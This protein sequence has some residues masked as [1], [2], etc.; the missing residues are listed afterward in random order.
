VASSLADTHYFDGNPDQHL[1]NSFYFEADPIP[2]FHY[3]A[4]PDPA[5][6]QTDANL[7]VITGVQTLH[8]SIV[9]VNVPP[10]LHF[11]PS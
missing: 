3:Y 2:S 9:S 5:H 6:H 4:D 1:K 10:R 11:E 8:G 7:R